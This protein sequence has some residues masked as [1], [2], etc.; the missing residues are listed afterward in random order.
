MDFTKNLATI[1]NGMKR[2]KD[3]LTES[4]LSRIWK[5]NE[6]H[7]AGALTAF[8][9]GPDC[10]TDKPY[11]KKENA[12]RNKSLLAKLKTKG[13]GVTKLHGS[14]PEGGKTTKEISYFVV[15]LSDSGK[16]EK[17]LR[18]LG[19]EFEQDSILFIPKGAIKGDA[20]AHLI[21][22]N[23]CD[24]NWLGFG[25]KEVFNKGRM[26]YDSPIYTS[27]VNGRPFVF[28]SVGETVES[29]QTGFGTWAMHL[30]AERD[31]QEIDV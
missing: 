19:Q 1:N 12:Q 26:G 24:N 6:E 7:D 16:L 11:S 2:Y 4:S 28:E 9:K 14:Y 21:G 15:D 29:P 30:I 3:F 17:D 20:K 5:H 23:R 25:K 10:G 8:R 13:Y 27:K 31:W 18:K 22:T